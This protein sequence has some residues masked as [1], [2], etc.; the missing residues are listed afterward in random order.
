[1]IIRV[2]LE[3]LKT[4]LEPTL[5]ANLPKM[6]KRDYTSCMRCSRKLRRL[7]LIDI[8]KAECR[9]SAGFPYKVYFGVTE[10]GKNF[11]EMFMPKDNVKQK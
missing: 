3:R 10:K 9:D 2:D 7:G 6:W 8:T 11:L 1:M 4:F 5:Q